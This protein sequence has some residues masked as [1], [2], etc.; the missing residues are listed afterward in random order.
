MATGLAS[1]SKRESGR[2]GGELG[3]GEPR[4]TVDDWLADD[5]LVLSLRGSLDAEA[6]DRVARRLSELAAQRDGLRLTLDLAGVGAV[7]ERPAEDLFLQVAGVH[8]R[9]AIITLAGAQGACLA[10]LGRLG[11]QA[12]PR[13]GGGRPAGGRLIVGVTA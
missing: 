11:L 10:L 8:A 6:C 4:F 5:A 13:V 2:K 9:R 7:D 1:V 3:M 12:A